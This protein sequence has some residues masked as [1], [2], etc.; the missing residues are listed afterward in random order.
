MC[1]LVV[2]SLSLLFSFF[3][4]FRVHSGKLEQVTNFAIVGGTAKHCV[5]QYMVLFR[6]T[7]LGSDIAMKGGL[8]AR[9]CHAFLVFVFFSTTNPWEI[10]PM[11]FE[12][13]GGCSYYDDS[14]RIFDIVTRSIWK[15]LDPF[16][17][18]SRLTPIHQ[19]SPAVL[20]RA[21][22]ASMSTTPTTKTTTTTR[23]RWD[24]Y[25][26]MEWAQLPMP[27]KMRSCDHAS[28]GGRWHLKSVKLM[29]WGSRCGM[30]CGPITLRSSVVLAIK[31]NQLSTD[32]QSR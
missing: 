1:R 25:G 5:N 31:C 15:M 17:T 2:Q 12:H 28:W 13:Y 20:S 19:V 8:H 29:P 23:D 3:L 4:W 21:A 32:W 6:Y 18:A 16:T 22:C 27:Y 9:L 24:R 26:P 30:Q 10:E 14:C 11:V 7:S